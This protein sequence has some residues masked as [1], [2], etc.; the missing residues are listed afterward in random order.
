MSSHEKG[1]LV[2]SGRKTCFDS[3]SVRESGQQYLVFQFQDF[4][5]VFVNPLRL[6]FLLCHPVESHNHLALRKFPA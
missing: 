1:L 5:F 3:M 4:V 6:F 2:F